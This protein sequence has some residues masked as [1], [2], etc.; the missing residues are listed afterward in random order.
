MKKSAEARILELLHKMELKQRRDFLRL[1]F[2]LFL[3]KR[4]K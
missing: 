4:G 2:E 3:R 1:C